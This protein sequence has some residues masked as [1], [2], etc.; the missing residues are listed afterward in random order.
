MKSS[1]SGPVWPKRGLSTVC[2]FLSSLRVVGVLNICYLSIKNFGSSL[3]VD[4]KID[5]GSPLF[6][7][8]NNEIFLIKVAITFKF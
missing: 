6:S 8:F 7:T 1:S 2:I 3:Y 4:I 5:L